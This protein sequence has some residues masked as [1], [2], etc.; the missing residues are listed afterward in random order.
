[1]SR[2]DQQA[3]SR[4]AEAQKQSYP[5]GSR[6]WEVVESCKVRRPAMD[7]HLRPPKVTET[8]CALRSINFGRRK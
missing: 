5:N 3:G 1:M 6:P 2:R 8:W 4:R 7:S